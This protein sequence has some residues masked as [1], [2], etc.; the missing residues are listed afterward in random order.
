MTIIIN[1]IYVFLLI[2]VVVVVVGNIDFSLYESILVEYKKKNLQTHRAT[3][4]IH[5][6]HILPHFYSQ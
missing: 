6:I 2:V 5:V 1:C 3:R 4:G